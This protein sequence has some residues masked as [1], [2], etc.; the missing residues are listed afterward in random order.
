MQ[1]ILRSPKQ[2]LFQGVYQLQ[3]T[4]KQQQHNFISFIYF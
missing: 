4:K 1:V 3:A 2:F